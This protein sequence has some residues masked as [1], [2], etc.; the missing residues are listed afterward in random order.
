MFKNGVYKS[1]CITKMLLLYSVRKNSINGEIEIIAKIKID[2]RM[3][4]V[5]LV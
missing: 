5:N 1:N 3:N 2:T 4:S